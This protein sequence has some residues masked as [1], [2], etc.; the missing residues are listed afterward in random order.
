MKVRAESACVRAYNREGTSTFTLTLFAEL[1]RNVELK[2]SKTA[3]GWDYYTLAAISTALL[4]GALEV[5]KASKTKSDK[6]K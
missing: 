3:S 1:W 2:E 5:S 6:S 4:F